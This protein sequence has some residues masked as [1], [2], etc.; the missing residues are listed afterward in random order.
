MKYKSEKENADWNL[1]DKNSL[2][3]CNYFS[4][5]SVNSVAKFLGD[6]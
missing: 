1:K 4:V 3:F 6:E 5:F 2:R